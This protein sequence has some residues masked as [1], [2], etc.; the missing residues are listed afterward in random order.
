MCINKISEAVFLGNEI[1]VIFFSVNN[2]GYIT[3]FLISLVDFFPTS[4]LKDPLISIVFICSFVI[5]LLK[6]TF[7]ATSHYTFDTFKNRSANI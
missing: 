7:I 2:A 6:V 3:G 4:F 5:V 1:D